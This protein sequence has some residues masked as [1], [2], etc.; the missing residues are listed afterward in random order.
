[1]YPEVPV[2]FN[3]VKRPAAVFGSLDQ[4]SKLA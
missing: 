2:F 1:M 3:I 4:G